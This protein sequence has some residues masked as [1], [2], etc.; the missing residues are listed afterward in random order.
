MRQVKEKRYL[1]HARYGA[2]SQRPIDVSVIKSSRKEGTVSK[3]KALQARQL[4]SESGA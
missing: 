4:T 1:E 3:L 2:L